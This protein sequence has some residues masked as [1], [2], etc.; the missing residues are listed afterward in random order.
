LLAL[1][2]DLFHDPAAMQ[3]FPP[4]GPSRKTDGRPS[5]R[6][7]GDSFSRLFSTGSHPTVGQ[8]ALAASQRTERGRRI[9]GDIRRGLFFACVL[10]GVAIVL[11][12]FVSEL[13]PSELS[14]LR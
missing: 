2:S 10:F 3:Q 8:D 1:R 4:T 9:A 5:E 6:P 12:L 14:P 7:S 13:S 11:A